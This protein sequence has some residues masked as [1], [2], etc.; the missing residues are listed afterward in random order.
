[1]RIEQSVLDALNKCAFNG[2]VITMPQLDREL[3]VKVNK[4]LEIIGA[5]WSRKDKGHTVEDDTWDKLAEAMTVGEVLDPKKELQF[6]PTPPDL[7][8]RM[9]DAAG[10]LAGRRVLE[11][12][13]GT[14]N[15]V[16]AIFNAATGADCVKVVAIEIESR[17]VDILAEQR[18]KTVY[19]NE[20]NFAIINADFLTYSGDLGLFDAVI[21]NPPFRKGQD[22][23]HVTKAYHLL[24]PV[25]RLVAITSPG[26]TFRNDANHHT[27]RSS[28]EALKSNA[29]WDRLEQGTFKEAGT[30][31]NTILL[32][33]TRPT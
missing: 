10:I 14:G 18:L 20:S 32:T 7:C 27:F 29:H 13:A 33:L 1:M 31:V 5:K 21:M 30:M 9:T 17:F 16:R 4:V 24:K 26:W 25:G 15:I 2:N 8:R 23:A 12:S 11:P 22:I 3:Y 6:Y 19:A 28:V